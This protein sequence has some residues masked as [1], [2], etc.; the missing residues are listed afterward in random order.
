MFAS[1]AAELIAG[2]VIVP[3]AIAAK[4]T[5]TAAVERLRY[6]LMMDLSLATSMLVCPA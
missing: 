2:V 5:A 6:H 3:T 1:Q 4:A